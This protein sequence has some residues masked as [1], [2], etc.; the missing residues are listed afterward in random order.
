MIGWLQCSTGASGDM[1]LGALVAA[2][3]PVEV[4]QAAVDL[5]APEPVTLAVSTVDRAGVCAVKVDV[6]VEESHVHRTWGDVRELLTARE[7]TG[8]D[9][10]LAA[11]RSLAEAEGHVHGADP[12]S[13]HFHEVGALDAIADVVGACAGLA[14][15]GLDRLV[16]SPVALGGGWVGAAHGRLAVPGPAVVQLLLGIPTHGGPE[17]ME[18]TT[19]TGAALLRTWVD[20]WGHQPTLRA[21]R[22]GFGAGG[23]DLARRA[24]VLRLVLGDEEPVTTEDRPAPTHRDGARPPHRE[25]HPHGHDAHG[26]VHP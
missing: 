7:W 12:E 2:G 24:N 4:M 17:P 5:V 10:A 23:R 25:E 3:V 15:L 21:R 1:F 22:Q 18:L 16:A 6:V 26:V 8:R 19:P 11:F 9:R 14:H 13:V 20:D